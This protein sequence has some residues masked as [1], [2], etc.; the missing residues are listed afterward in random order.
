MK[1]IQFKTFGNPELLEYVDLPTPQADADSAVVQVKAASVNPSDVKNVSGH[2][3]HTVLPRTP[4]RDFS[5]VVTAGPAEW[6]GAA[7]KQ[8]ANVVGRSVEPQDGPPRSRIEM[9]VHAVDERVMRGDQKVVDAV[10]IEVA[11]R[12]GIDSEVGLV[13]RDP[14]A[15]GVAVEDRIGVG[16]E[17]EAGSRHSTDIAPR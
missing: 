3:E 13:E 17:D 10:S 11:R 16:G 7:G 14:V 4:G 1:A 6:L 8:S 2:F 5:C 12:S 15:R 9:P